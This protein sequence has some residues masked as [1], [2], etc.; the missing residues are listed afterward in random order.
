M[1]LSGSPDAER[2]LRQ[3]GAANPIA[4]FELPRMAMFDSGALAQTTRRVH[5]AV[6]ITGPGLP[7]PGPWDVRFE[8]TTNSFSPWV[9]TK[10]T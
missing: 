1:P 7:T 5:D 6:S 3:V 10:M 4:A 9:V 8:V 2:R